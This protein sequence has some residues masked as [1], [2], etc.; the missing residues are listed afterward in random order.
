LGK[1]KRESNGSELVQ[2]KKPE[3]PHAGTRERKRVCGKKKLVPSTTHLRGKKGKGREKIKGG[4]RED[5]NYRGV[6]RTI[7]R[8]GGQGKRKARCA[9]GP[10]KD[11]KK[12]K[13]G[14]GGLAL[15]P[16][17]EQ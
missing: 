17:I 15:N 1:K 9:L 10:F 2:K 11:K 6:G 7:G 8:R 16:K 14:G 3:S 4:A 13:K 12:R 5:T